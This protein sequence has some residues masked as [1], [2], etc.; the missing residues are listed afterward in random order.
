MENENDYSEKPF[1][2]VI[3]QTMNWGL[4]GKHFNVKPYRLTPGS[5][6]VMQVNVRE[7]IDIHGVGTD[8][9]QM[10]GFFTV[11]TEDPIPVEKEK[12]INW[13]NFKVLTKFKALELV[14][15]SDVF[16]AVR[17]RLHET[18][19]FKNQG[20]VE[21]Q[22]ELS[23]LNPPAK[24]KA[25]LNVTMELPDMKMEIQTEKPVQMFSK[26]I[27]IPPIGDV[28]RSEH[29]S[30]LVD[31]NTGKVFGEIVSSDIEVGKVIHSQPLRL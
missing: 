16:G 5:I 29:G 15:Q 26:V 14:G 30:N 2:P 21:S 9:V 6:E 25:E 1:K 20:V 7:K 31:I 24:C 12:D 3:G 10:S 11:Q 19:E 23:A 4:T 22:S 17:V 8:V 27:Q 18:A 28:A 13:K